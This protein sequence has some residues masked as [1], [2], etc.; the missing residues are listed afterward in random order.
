[1]FALHLRHRQGV[2]PAYFIQLTNLVY[3]FIYI[4]KNYFPQLTNCLALVLCQI[5]T[6]S[7]ALYH[8]Q[9]DGGVNAL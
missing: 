9:F 6:C 5:M 1:M 8:I 7:S 2:P 4:T 3:L